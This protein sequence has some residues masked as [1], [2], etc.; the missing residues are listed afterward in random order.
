MSGG[1]L[2]AKRVLARIPGHMVARRAGIGR[3]RLSE[4]ELEHINPPASELSR[5]ERA[6]DELILAK[7]RVAEVANECGY[8]VSGI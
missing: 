7:R 3:G 6:L 8:P 1:Q 4:I 5:V 2:R